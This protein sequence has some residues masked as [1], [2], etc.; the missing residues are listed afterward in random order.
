VFL[1][2]KEGLVS[3]PSPTVVLVDRCGGILSTALTSDAFDSIFSCSADESHWIGWLI[4]LI[5][6]RII[7]VFSFVDYPPQSH[8][9][10]PRRAR[11][12]FPHSLIPSPSYAPTLLRINSVPVRVWRCQCTHRSFH[13]SSSVAFSYTLV[14]YA[15]DECSTDRG[16]C[17][18]LTFWM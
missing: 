3:W 18:R 2:W 6:L 1:I 9:S 15:K 11:R 5:G 14:L 7:L 16:N 12:R 13:R 17:A 10:A 8:A 4:R